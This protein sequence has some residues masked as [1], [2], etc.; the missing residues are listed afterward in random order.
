MSKRK[1]ELKRCISAVSLRG[2]AACLL[3]FPLAASA[4]GLDVTDARMRV[5][6]G[7]T[8]AA[9]YFRLGNTSDNTVVLVGARSDAFG[10]VELHRSMNK[11]GM[12]SM[13]PVSRLEVA[14]GEELTFAPQGYHLM[15]MAP[16]GTLSVGDEVGITLEF[17]QRE[18]LVVDFEA[19]P[20]TA[21]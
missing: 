7:D 3:A 12:A 16:V 19:V 13:A 10:R 21:M 15:L 8:P 17:E 11:D 1:Q 20:P 5:L 14:P 9:G 4:D 6:P 2:L 18:P